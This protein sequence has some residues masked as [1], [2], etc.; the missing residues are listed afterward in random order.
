MQAGDGQGGGRQC[1][2]RELAQVRDQ[3][4]VLTD[5]SQPVIKYLFGK[6]RH[7]HSI[8][9]LAEALDVLMHTLGEPGFAGKA[10]RVAL[11]TGASWHE[12]DRGTNAIGTALAEAC[13]IEIHGA[14]HYLERNA[15]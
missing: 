1:A 11:T 15:S 12:Q 5:H 4:R 8:V 14:E 3:N 6:V 7:S 2:G 13:E 9:G 10:E